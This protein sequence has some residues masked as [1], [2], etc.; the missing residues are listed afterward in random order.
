MTT[1]G[2]GGKPIANKSYWRSR[3]RNAERNAAGEKFK[4]NALK[5]HFKLVLPK[6]PEDIRHE[7]YRLL[8]TALGDA[9][10]ARR[11]NYS[12]QLRAASTH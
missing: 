6:C 5:D 8:R 3:K 9:A 7:L 12:R 11:W 1:A 2:N 10:P 4:I